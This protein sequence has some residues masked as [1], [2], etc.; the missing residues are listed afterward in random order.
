MRRDMI[1][2]RSVWQV[3]GDWAEKCKIRVW[4]YLSYGKILE[5]L[6][7]TSQKDCL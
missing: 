6:T 1:D 2:P 3:Q 7:C 5:V 4:S